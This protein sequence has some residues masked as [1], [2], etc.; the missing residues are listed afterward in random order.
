MF[1]LSFNQPVH[2]F[3]KIRCCITTHII[4]KIKCRMSEVLCFIYEMVFVGF[5]FF[6]CLF[7]L[8]CNMFVSRPFYNMGGFGP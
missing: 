8:V 5:F 3:V 7:D 2:F 1:L 4:N 6:I